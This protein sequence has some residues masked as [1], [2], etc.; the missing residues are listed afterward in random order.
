MTPSWASVARRGRPVVVAVICLFLAPA[1]V[2]GPHPAQAQASLAQ[3]ST[4]P[5]LTR[6]Q[7]AVERVGRQR[8]DLT[9]DVV[10]SPDFAF[11]IGTRT[12]MVTP[13]TVFDPPGRRLDNLQAGEEVTAVVTDDGTATEVTVIDTD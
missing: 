4:Q 6:W 3:V 11:D 10:W 12:V 7:G 1:V 5:R 13:A 9:V 2:G 8:F